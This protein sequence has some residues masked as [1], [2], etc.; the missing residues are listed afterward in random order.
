MCLPGCTSG[1]HCWPGQ[2]QPI[3]VI[4]FKC[5]L[6][7]HLCN[8]SLFWLNSPP[9]PW[10]LAFTGEDEIIIETL[11]TIKTNVLI[12]MQI[13]GR[14]PLVQGIKEGSCLKYILGLQ[15]WCDA[16]RG[17]QPVC[18]NFKPLTISMHSIFFV[19][20][21]NSISAGFE[22]V[23]QQ[24]SWQL[25]C[26]LNYSAFLLKSWKLLPQEGTMIS[27]QHLM[28]ILEEQLLF[29]VLLLNTRVNYHDPA[30]I[31]IQPLRSQ[32][33]WQFLF[34]YSVN[35]IKPTGIISLENKER[36]AKIFCVVSQN[37][38]HSHLWHWQCTIIQNVY[39]MFHI[40]L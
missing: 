22:I 19:I 12:C 16:D 35:W 2:P 20:S 11:N 1:A 5:Y 17:E 33:S 36:H 30:G 3:I 23:D 37:E 21:Y 32:S 14:N 29:L 9:Y 28:W 18:F 40:A 6:F 25:W 31:H 7:V 4:N 27:C 10:S 26:E 15:E 34:S 39:Y 38:T 8:S 24:L 13:S